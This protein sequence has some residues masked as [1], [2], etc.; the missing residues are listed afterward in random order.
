MVSLKCSFLRLKDKF[1]YRF[2]CVVFCVFEFY[3]CVLLSKDYFSRSTFKYFLYFWFGEEN[4]H[5][6]LVDFILIVASFIVKLYC[7]LNKC[8]KLLNSIRLVDR[9]VA[10]RDFQFHIKTRGQEFSLKDYQATKASHPSLF[11]LL[12]QEFKTKLFDFLLVT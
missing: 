6:F 5:S 2:F 12:L 8:R 4:L 9:W 11:Y 10:L 3:L 1:L 7:F